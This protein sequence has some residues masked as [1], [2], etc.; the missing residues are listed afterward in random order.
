MRRIIS[1]LTVALI[2]ALMIV[3]MAVPAF[4][5]GSPCG[6]EISGFARESGPSGNIGFFISQEAGAGFGQEEVAG[7]C[8][9]G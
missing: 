1:I 2:M 3:A 9:P 4:A 6:E 8:Q 7:F 5:Q